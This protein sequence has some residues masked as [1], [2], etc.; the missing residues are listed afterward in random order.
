MKFDP[1]R[2]GSRLLRQ[3]S[4][5]DPRAPWWVNW[6]LQIAITIGGLAGIAWAADRLWLALTGRELGALCLGWNLVPVDLLLPLG[7]AV[8]CIGMLAGIAGKRGAAMALIVAG[9]LMGALPDFAADAA[10]GWSCAAPFGAA[11]AFR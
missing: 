5:L 2:E 10:M 4:P 6:L 7:L 3:A 1:K 11:P 8:F 9:A